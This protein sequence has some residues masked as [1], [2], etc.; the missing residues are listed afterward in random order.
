MSPLVSS[1]TVTPRSPSPLYDVNGDPLP[2]SS[3]SKSPCSG[4]LL[5]RTSAPEPKTSN[6]GSSTPPSK[7]RDSG[8]KRKSETNLL[9]GTAAQ[10][11]AAGLNKST[12]VLA[13]PRS[14]PLQFARQLS[15]NT[16]GPSLRSSRLI[17]CR[18]CE[19]EYPQ[20]WI[21]LHTEYCKRAVEFDKPETQCD[22]RLHTF[23]RLVKRHRKRI[24]GLGASYYSQDTYVSIE[25]I[26]SQAIS[27]RYGEKD[28]VSRCWDLI[29]NLQKVLGNL[30]YEDIGLVTY[31]RRIAVIMEE[32]WANLREFDKLRVNN[33]GPQHQADTWG[34]LA[35]AKSQFTSDGP[36]LFENRS[37]ELLMHNNSRISIED[38]KIIKKIS[39][40]AYGKVY[41]A[42]KLKTKDLYAVKIQKKSDMLRKNM[43][44]NVMAE[45]RILSNASNPY[46]VKLYYAFQNER[47][48][49]LVMEYCCGG[50]VATLLRNLVAFDIDMTRVYAAETVLSLVSLHKQSYVHRDLKPDNMLINAKGHIVLTDFG[51]STMGVIDRTDK[52]RLDNISNNDSS[53]SPRQKPRV[54]GTPDYLAPEILMGTG[55][56]GPEVDWWALGVIVYEFLTGVPPFSGDSPQEIFDRILRR[57]IL[58]P[59]EMDPVARDFIDKLLVLNPDKRLGHNGADEVKS[60]PFFNGI[61]WDTVYE[62][63]RE[64]IF[65]PHL[66]DPEDTSY[67]DDH[68][69][70]IAA[71]HQKQDK[72]PSPLSIS[73]RDKV[74]EEATSP[75]SP[76]SESTSPHSDNPNSPTNNIPTD[77]S[78]D[79][80]SHNPSGA[81]ESPPLT[82]GSKKEFDD[83]NFTNTQVLIEKTLE[84]ATNDVA[85]ANAEEGGENACGAEHSV[86]CVSDV[87]STP[88][89]NDLEPDEM[90]LAGSL[91]D[92][93]NIPPKQLSVTP[94]PVPNSSLQSDSDS[95]DLPPTPTTVVQMF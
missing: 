4:A 39:S 33:K 92:K 31:G 47:Y 11:T 95:D 14:R 27:L 66:D 28:A 9:Q 5:V 52:Q 41:L 57:D 72:A 50:D 15:I 2:P 90:L 89:Q 1:P 62:E 60:H 12:S 78:E 3:L 38:F 19:E 6:E 37:E 7:L 40:G 74:K 75:V 18:I 93:N 58:W 23:V 91:P 48:L 16:S 76:T 61:N 42:R 32:K 70:M 10:A 17:L 25:T 71:Q 79:S 64:D 55:H 56:G 83:F 49:Y 59:K 43:V 44:E 8:S 87:S 94:P 68:G 45:R 82:P 73:P 53:I 69:E 51:L 84:I 30:S 86:S 24:V 22:N 13:T 21:K 63:N 77:A 26:A 29:M 20:S 36:S 81:F 88:S 85:S 67:F 46:I 65:V 54:V 34:L 80:V 35:L